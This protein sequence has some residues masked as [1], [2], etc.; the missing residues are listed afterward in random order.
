MDKDVLARINPIYKNEQEYLKHLASAGTANALALY[1]ELEFGDDIGMPGEMTPGLSALSEEYG[2]SYSVIE[3]GIEIADE[4]R[5]L[6]TNE[7]IRGYEPTN[8]IEIP[9]GYTPR[10]LI[11]A[12]E[13][14]KYIGLDLPIVISDI[15]PA[16]R[17]LTDKYSHR[18]IYRSMDAT[19]FG[20]ISHAL[21]NVNGEI[22]IISEIMLSYLTD[23]ELISVCDNIYKLLS[24][25]GGCWITM[26]TGCRD[27]YKN[28]FRCLAPDNGDAMYERL[29]KHFKKIA[30]ID[31]YRN[32]L[33]TDGPE[34]AENF[35]KFRGFDIEKVSVSEVFPELA[36][37]KDMPEVYD[38]LK[39]AFSKMEYWTLTASKRHGTR[40]I[41]THS[42]GY[43]VDKKTGSGFLYLGISGR[44]DTITAPDLLS[45]YEEASKDAPLEKITI[46]C[47]NLEY[48]SSAG[49]R[50]LLIMLKRLK[51]PGGMTVRNVSDPVMEILETT[52]FTDLI[53]NITRA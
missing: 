2:A 45:V 25:K 22:T 52:G 17:N 38:K 35:L 6:M 37:L 7:M 44:L 12:N 29:V 28:V 16:V 47:R 51:T 40:I 42:Q 13:G 23:S 31:L 33:Y 53:E 34:G 4:A 50:V 14:Y 8:I 27:L 32:S 36:T 1:K 39:D 9:C 30:D 24:I 15:G 46:D 48:I 26:D 18:I 10:G 41:N 11:M 49:L 20:S 5:F 3:K 43:S 19:N 21:E